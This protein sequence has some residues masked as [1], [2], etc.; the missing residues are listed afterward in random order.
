MSVDILIKLKT[1]LLSFLDE[2][3]QSF[4][5]EGDFVIFRIF[6]N[7][8]V[9]IAEIMN[10][11]VNK[12]CPLENLVKSRNDKFFLENNILFS[13]FDD[14]QTSKVNHFRNLWQSPD[15]D[16]EDREA[17]WR[18]FENFISLGNEYRKSC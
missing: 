15:V 7:D 1:N 3:I 2:L 4:P 10:Y 9:P 14:A 17:I 16:N 5:A 6:V 13:N 18:W 8:R 11:I 12:L